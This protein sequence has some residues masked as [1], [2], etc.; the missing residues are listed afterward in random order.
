MGKIASIKLKK[1]GKSKNFL[2]ILN[3]F[4][5][6]GSKYKIKWLNKKQC[7]CYFLT[8]FFWVMWRRVLDELSY[9]YSS[10]KTQPTVSLIANS[11]RLATLK[12]HAPC[13]SRYLSYLFWCAV[14][15]YHQATIKRAISMKRP[16]AHYACLEKQN[17]LVRNVRARV[18]CYTFRK[19]KTVVSRRVVARS[20]FQQH[21]VSFHSALVLMK[22]AT[23]NLRS[24]YRTDVSAGKTLIFCWRSRTI[25]VAYKYHWCNNKERD[26]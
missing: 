10:Y 2:F 23:I 19:Q 26:V 21:L 7:Y 1:L 22:D 14:A 5:G 13:S 16:N 24:N 12:R 6:F 25:M 20:H 11:C 4:N 8:P 15:S 18:F 3:Y 17:N 9:L